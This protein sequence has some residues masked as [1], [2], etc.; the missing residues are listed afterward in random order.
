MLS[1]LQKRLFILFRRALTRTCQIAPYFDS[2]SRELVHRCNHFSATK[3]LFYILAEQEF[4]L[5]IQIFG[6]FLMTPFGE[7]RR[8]HKIFKDPNRQQRRKAPEDK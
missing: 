7:R 4:A 5:G 6:A 2:F 8:S 1:H 3:M